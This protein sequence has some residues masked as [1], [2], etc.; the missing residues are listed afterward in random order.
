MSKS[1]ALVKAIDPKSAFSVTVVKD[2]KGNVTKETWNGLSP[3]FKTQLM[4]EGESLGGV[5]KTITEGAAQ[6]AQI[7]MTLHAAFTTYKRITGE[8]LPHFVN[9]Q[10]DNTCPNTYGKVGSDTRN[11]INSHVVFNGL[12]YLY[13]KAVKA[14]KAAE[15]RAALIKAGV[16]VG[17]SEEVTKY[18]KDAR[19][20]KRDVFEAD[21]CK[22]VLGFDR[23]GVSDSTVENL[24]ILMGKH[25]KNKKDTLNKVG[26]A[27]KTAALN[28]VFK[29]REV[30][31]V[32]PKETK[33]TA[34]KK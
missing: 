18:N 32:T 23:F 13:D 19:K 10:V 29:H 9:T 31:D 34:T 15:E 17:D 3:A 25:E 14:V 26:E 24:L 22:V 7:G 2:K 30:R 5:L 12:R 4:K 21:F 27:L 1:Q 16:N 20:E 33:K 11:T 8:G 28:K 6:R